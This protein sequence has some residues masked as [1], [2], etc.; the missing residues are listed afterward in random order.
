MYLQS[1]L[2]HEEVETR[3]IKKTWNESR[4]RSNWR[5]I[6]SYC[7]RDEQQCVR[8]F[9]L[10]SSVQPILHLPAFL[11]SRSKSIRKSNRL[12]EK[13]ET[14]VLVR[15]LGGLL[16]DWLGGGSCCRCSG[17]ASLGNRSGRGEGLWVL[18]V[19]LNLFKMSAKADQGSARQIERD[20]SA[21]K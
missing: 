15:L 13:A 12:V 9:G 20:P 11:F 4:R 14:H 6:S 7:S 8:S 2:K 19:V 10:Q 1:G 21:R 17:A 16:L 18:E 3:G 5:L